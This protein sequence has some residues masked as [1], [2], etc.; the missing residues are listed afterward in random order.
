M[1]QNVKLLEKYDFH[2]QYIYKL[3]QKIRKTNPKV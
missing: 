3:P 1:I 2:M